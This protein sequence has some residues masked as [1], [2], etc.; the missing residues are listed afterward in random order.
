MSRFAAAIGVALLST[1]QGCAALY[2]PDR[3]KAA[4]AAQQAFSDA[5]IGQAMQDERK[6]LLANQAERQ[7]LVKRQELALRD[8]TLA[9]VI[10]GT[11]PA[12]TWDMLRTETEN[13]LAALRGAVKPQAQGCHPLAKDA[14]QYLVAETEKAAL[15]A[16]QVYLATIDSEQAMSLS[17]QAIPS[18]LPQGASPVVAALL[19]GYDEQCAVVNKATACLASLEGSGGT[20]GAI[21][22]QIRQAQ[23]VKATYGADIAKTKKVLA[24]LI[25][26]ADSA[27]GG[28]GAAASFATGVEAQLAK[29]ESIKPGKAK[30]SNPLLARLADEGRLASLEQKRALLEQYLAALNGADNADATPALHRTRLIA[31]LV[32]HSTATTAPPTAG[33]LMQA[34]FFRQQIDTAKVRNA[35]ADA[36]MHIAE[37]KRAALSAELD[38]LMQAQAH[39]K[40][41]AR[42]C[43]LAKPYFNSIA[44]GSGSP[45]SNLASRALLAFAASWT[46]GRL[47]ATQ[48]DYRLIEQDELAAL[49]ES[50]AALQQSESVLKTI[51]AQIAKLN[52]AGI[53]PEDIAGLWQAAAATVIAIRVK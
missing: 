40:E 29:L 38:Y 19:Q 15:G 5:A 14:R 3:D 17:C 2:N 31:D 52:A 51:F 27:K 45:C 4:Q 18:A 41:A 16:A 53:K 13:R 48:A 10:D 47:P 42:H 37:G 8:A 26:E 6:V 9:L 36:I 20:L 44:R 22:A 24:K 39:L 21:S 50:E 30:G 1:L 23:E 35:R 33:I 25:A 28:L 43:D 49:D 32:N 7:A 46:A 12:Y 11:T 34:E